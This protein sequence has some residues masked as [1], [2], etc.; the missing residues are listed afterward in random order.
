MTTLNHAEDV[1]DEIERRIKTIKIADGFETDIG[2]RVMMGRRK[3]PAEDEMPCAVIIEA[4]D[5]TDDESGKSRSAK[6]KVSLP[7]VID[8]FDRC[9]PDNPNRKAHAMLRDMKKVIF[10][11]DRMLNGLV[12]SLKYIGKDIGPRPDGA[13]MVMARLMIEV[14]YVEDLSNP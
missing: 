4:D 3:L 9:D 13:A 6:V 8:A 12:H 5:A 14:Y 2:M 11:G 1:A 10:N 7:L